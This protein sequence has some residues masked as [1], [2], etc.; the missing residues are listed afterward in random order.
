MVLSRRFKFYFVFCVVVVLLKFG[1][2][3][4]YRRCVIR[5]FVIVFYLCKDYSDRQGSFDES[6]I[7]N[8]DIQYI[9]ELEL[10]IF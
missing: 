1:L 10:K 9:E 3:L 2:S 7:S 8:Y 4:F 5:R 6:K